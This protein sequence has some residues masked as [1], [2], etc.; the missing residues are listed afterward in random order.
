MLQVMNEFALKFV[1]VWLGLSALTFITAHVELPF[2]N[3]PV[4]V[5]ERPKTVEEIFHEL[6]LISGAVRLMQ[7]TIPGPLTMHPIALIAVS[8]GIDLPATTVQIAVFPPAFFDLTQ[9]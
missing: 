8:I 1:T 7:N 6:T 2:V 4:S 5:T 3:R 9:L